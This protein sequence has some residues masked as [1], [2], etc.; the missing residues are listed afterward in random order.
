[1]SLHSNW[2]KNIHAIWGK[3]LI[4]IDN[5]H[6]LVSNSLKSRYKLELLEDGLSNSPIYAEMKEWKES[7]CII[8][9]EY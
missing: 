8:V 7:W 1:M 4:Q 5:I 6:T 9:V 3:V 2:E